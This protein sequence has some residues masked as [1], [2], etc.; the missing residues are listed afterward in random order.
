MLS[1]LLDWLETENELKIVVTEVNIC[2]HID[3][4]PKFWGIYQTVIRN[5]CFETLMGAK[6]PLLLILYEYER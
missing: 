2:L 1:S 6:G 5:I 4:I 3:F